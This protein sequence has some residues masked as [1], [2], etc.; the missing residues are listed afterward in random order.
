M[1]ERLRRL[2]SCILL[3]AL[4]LQMPVF[5]EQSTSDSQLKEMSVR[6]NNP[7]A[8]MTALIYGTPDTWVTIE[9]ITPGKSQKEAYESE[10]TQDIFA[11]FDMQKI[12]ESGVLEYPYTADDGT[13]IYTLRARGE[14]TS[15]E[16][17]AEGNR[18][19]G[20]QSDLFFAELWNDAYTDV[21]E[22]YIQGAVWLDTTLIN[23]GIEHAAQTVKKHM[24]LRQPGRKY[25]YIHTDIANMNAKSGKFI[26]QWEDVEEQAAY[27]DKF[28]NVYYHMG[29]DLDGIYTD[30]ENTM[31]PW[32]FKYVP[33]GADSQT[34]IGN[35]LEEVVSDP[36]YQNV[37]RPR[38]VE[39]GFEFNTTKNELYDVPY[40]NS[41]KDNAYLI[42]TA[43]LD[44]YKSECLT[45][46]I[47]EPAKKYYPD[48]YYSNY[49]S[50]D[51]ITAYYTGGAH[52]YYVGGNRIK[53]GTHSSPVLY[54]ASAGTKRYYP[55]G[56][57]YTIDATPFAEA[58]SLIAGMKNIVISS[59]DGKTMPWVVSEYYHKFSY[60]DE[61]RPYFYEYLLHLGLCNPDAF[62]HYGPIYY[63]GEEENPQGNVDGMRKAM[64]E[65]NAYADKKTSKT[66]VDDTSYRE[67]PFIL[68]GMQT[69]GRFLF[70]ITPDNT[71]LEEGKEFCTQKEGTPT[72]Y[73]DGY[74]IS[75]PGGTILPNISSTY[76]SWVET[77]IGV[78]PKIVNENENETEES[79]ILLKLYDKNGIEVSEDNK[80]DAQTAVLFYKGMSGKD[81]AASIAKYNN[82]KMTDIKTEEKSKFVDSVGR[83]VIKNINK[84]TLPNDSKKMFIWQGFETLNPITP[85]ITLK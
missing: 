30:N 81:I 5:A 25:L 64:E 68:S 10:N 27:L 14:I 44:S 7:D 75:F 65:L 23:K 55:D 29:G 24:D 49:S 28:F 69:K 3:S 40:H 34:V 82:G 56:T 52:R 79:S 4:L 32:G 50:N 66:L 61:D 13:G 11:G 67:Y 84:D 76:G 58:Q 18:L 63:G 43:V 6:I 35:R 77:P 51:R 12:P 20:S 16:Y 46:G 22:D 70:R 47:Y 74:R 1:M 59:D 73:I 37:I 38:L 2:L 54:S 33:D 48:V 26:W 72:F 17:A 39:R 83:I 42:W 21:C 62:L 78:Y 19:S 8:Q 15:V 41:A 53:A 9:L 31:C 80:E 71:K 57:V 36:T 85:E 60:I 45:A